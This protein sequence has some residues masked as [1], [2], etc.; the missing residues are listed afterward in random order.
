MGDD[1]YTLEEQLN[2]E[3]SN[4]S[5]LKPSKKNDLMKALERTKIENCNTV[6]SIISDYKPQTKTIHGNLRDDVKSSRK[7]E[8][9]GLKVPSVDTMLK[10]VESECAELFQS[11]QYSKKYSEEEDGCGINLKSEIADSDHCNKFYGKKSNADV[12][13]NSTEGE[14]EL[15]NRQS[16]HEQPQQI[17]IGGETS[18]TSKNCERVG[19]AKLTFNE[20]AEIVLKDTGHLKNIQ[21][22]EVKESNP[23]S[24]KSIVENNTHRVDPFFPSLETLRRNNQFEND[25]YFMPS[26]QAKRNQRN[27]SIIEYENHLYNL[28]E[29]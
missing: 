15:H 2:D 27:A 14:I 16:T 18:H 7:L 6:L 9:L 5:N 12:R 21:D 22:L 29:N 1:P 11:G 13:H 3:G 23:N 4:T 24:L 20:S 8:R 25:D 19:S 10:L 28:D 17:K 26:F